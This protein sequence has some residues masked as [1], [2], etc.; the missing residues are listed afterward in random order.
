MMQPNEFRVLYSF[1]GMDTT[2]IVEVGVSNFEV[3]SSS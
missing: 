2:M 1:L 3:F